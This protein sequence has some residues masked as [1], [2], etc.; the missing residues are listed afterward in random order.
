[1]EREGYKLPAAY[2]HEELAT[3]IGAGRVAVSRAFKE[4]REMGAVEAGR[5]TVC[6]RDPKILKRIARSEG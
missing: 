2:T 3:M 4:L 6:V 1:M 5:A